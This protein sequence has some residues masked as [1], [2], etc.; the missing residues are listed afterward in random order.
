MN[1]GYLRHRCW[2]KEPTHTNDG[3]GGI[4]TTWGTTTVCWGALEPLKGKEWFDSGMENSSITS[5]FRMRYVSGISPTMRLYF[6]TQE[7]QIISVIDAGEKHRQ[8]EL[9][10]KRLVEV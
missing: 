7:F 8:M 1:A 6:G 10:V 2:I 5:R 9:M 3:Y 4:T